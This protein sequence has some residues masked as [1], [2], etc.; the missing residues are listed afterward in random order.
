MTTNTKS[1]KGTADKFKSKFKIKGNIIGLIVAAIVLGSS[2]LLGNLTGAFDELPGFGGV[3]HFNFQTVLR[4]IIAVAFTYAFN[5]L[6]QIIIKLIPRKNSRA[7]TLITVLASVVRYSAVLIGICWVLTLLGVGVG[8]VFAGVGIVALV[9]GFGAESLVADLVTG[10]FIIFENQFNVGD[11]IEVDGF[12]GTV[13]FIGIR[14]T[15]I[16]DMGKNLKIINNSDIKN[17][18]NRSRSTSVAVVEVGVSYATDLRKVDEV[19]DG[20]LADIKER[21]SKIFKGD[22]TYLGVDNLADSSVVLK[23]VA[24]VKEADIFTGKRLLNK[25]IKCAFDD[26]G[27]E[28]AFPQIDVHMK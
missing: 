25:E 7:N 18:L 4:V 22:I 17:V 21:N 9:V 24:D 20:I 14:T 2:G 1:K 15:G 27:I 19:I 6:A 12:R 28:I 13:D 23:F 26:A 8:T 5:S 16:R 3:I 10:L 11:I